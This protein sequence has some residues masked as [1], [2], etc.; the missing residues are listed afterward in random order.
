MRLKID[1]RFGGGNQEEINHQ[2]VIDV[3]GKIIRVLN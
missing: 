3:D 1:V 2:A